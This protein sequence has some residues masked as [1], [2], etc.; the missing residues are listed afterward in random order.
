MANSCLASTYKDKE[1]GKIL[2]AIVFD[3]PTKQSRF[4][5]C[6]SL[7]HW[8]TNHFLRKNND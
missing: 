7:I 5:D 4:D 2:L 6:R 3:C 8:A 1:T